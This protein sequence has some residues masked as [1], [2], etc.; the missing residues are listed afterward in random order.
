MTAARLPFSLRLVHALRRGWRLGLAGLLS[1]LLGWGAP[2]GA[3]PVSTEPLSLAGLSA[4]RGEDGVS[5][6]FDLR[7]NLPRSVEDALLK[8]VP[9]HFV[10]EAELL[11]NRWYWTDRSV[12]HAQRS[13]RLAW[14]P[15]TRTW[16]VSFGGLHQLYPTLP[17]ALAVISR[18]SRWRIAEPQAVD[19]DARYSVV[20]SWRVDTTQLPRPLQFGLGDNDWDIG[21]QRT[22]PLGEGP[23]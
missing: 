18:T 15:L 23:R 21:I 4:S 10:A 19:D 13:W 14:Q 5:L 1:L 3:Q 16:R 11:R 6:A 8:G 7:L 12:A 9:L 20:F 17:E 2:V 22:V